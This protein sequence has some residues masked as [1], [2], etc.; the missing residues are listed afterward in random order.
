MIWWVPLF[1]ACLMALVFAILYKKGIG[2]NIDPGLKYR[3]QF[4]ALVARLEN[5]T[6]RVNVLARELS[7]DQNRTYWDTFELLLTQY[8]QL[9]DS[10]QAMPTISR[11]LDLIKASD[12]LISDLEQKFEAY[13]NSLNK[14]DG[15]HSAAKEATKK[16][17]VFLT[18][19][20][21]FCSRPFVLSEFRLVKVRIDG[22]ILRGIG[23]SVCRN[24]LK[25]KKKVKVLYFR[26]EGRQLHWSETPGY[27]P[28]PD[29]YDINEENKS[30]RERPNLS[31]V[32][33]RVMVEASEPE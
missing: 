13:V 33:S 3:E 17:G 22:N 20:C 11:S 12:A 32:Y 14:T 25:D 15:A 5:I 1:L 27:Q 10:M 16:A 30:D 31:L 9:L 23:C 6:V 29:Y 8:E 18:K 19:G 4:E 26:K 7:T 24:A 2:R 28:R 21:Y